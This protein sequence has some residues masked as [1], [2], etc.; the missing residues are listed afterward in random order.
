MEAANS[1]ESRV[2]GGWDV[3]M[4]GSDVLGIPDLVRE[5]MSFMDV[6]DICRVARTCKL[7]YAVTSADIFWTDVLLLRRPMKM[8]QVRLVNISLAIK[9]RSIG[10]HRHACVFRPPCPAAADQHHVPE[11]RPQHEATDAVRGGL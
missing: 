11:A 1:D 2:N 5:V 3:A 6:L 8:K 4:R 7:W 9:S 10:H